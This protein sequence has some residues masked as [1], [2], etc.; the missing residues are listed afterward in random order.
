MASDELLI[1]TP[2]PH[3]V[4]LRINRPQVRNALNLAVR[5]GI[6]EAVARYSDDPPRSP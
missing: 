6:A 5:R 3:I 4:L 2:A 1:E